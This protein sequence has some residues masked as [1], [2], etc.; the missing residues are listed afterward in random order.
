MEVNLGRLQQAI[1][2]GKLDAKKPIDAGERAG[3]RRRRQ[4]AKTASASLA[5]GELTA[6][7]N[8]E[9]AG[10][11]KAAVA[12]VEK[13]GGKVTI[14]GRRSAAEEARR[15]KAAKAGLKPPPSAEP[16]RPANNGR[17]A[18]RRT[19]RRRVIRPIE[20]RR[21]PWHQPPNNS[22]PISISA[23][24]A[25]ATELK[26]RIWFTLGALIVYRLGTYIPIPGIDPGVLWDIFQQQAGGILGMLDMFAGGALG[27][28][29]IFALN[30]MPYISAAIIMQL[31]TGGLAELEA[32]QEGRRDRAQEDQPVHPLRHRGAGRLAGLRHRRRPGGHDRAAGARRS[33]I[34]GC[35]SA[36]PP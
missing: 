16:P 17:G 15:K 14:A 26:K 6:K 9:V 25:K 20:D 8:L 22:P 7:V 11:S 33:P 18:S 10:A 32:A 27:R 13:A 4:K 21:S 19:G 2:A 24:F 23:P 12:A 35:S 29:T 28:M 30:I 1:D 5:K 31:M 34:P 36:P 3:R